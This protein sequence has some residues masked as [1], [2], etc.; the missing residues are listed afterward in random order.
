MTAPL[1]VR[2]HHGGLPQAFAELAATSRVAIVWEWEVTAAL[3]ARASGVVTTM[4]LDQI[5]AETWR[6]ALDAL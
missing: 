4:H 1:I 6:G 5:R 2:S 3:I